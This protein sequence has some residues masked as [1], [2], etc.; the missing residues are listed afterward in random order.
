[1]SVEQ[2]AESIR[3]LPPTERRK[4]CDWMEIHRTELVPDADDVNPAVREELELRLMEIEENP[5]LL[6]PFEEGALERM[7]QE[8][9]DVHA[10][11]SS[12]H[13]R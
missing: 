9:A 11:K 2:I 12:T 6:K 1:M 3:A 8:A 7:I 5:E 13:R 4:I 10:K